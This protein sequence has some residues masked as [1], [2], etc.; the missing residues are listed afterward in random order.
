MSVFAIAVVLSLLYLSQTSDVATTGYDITALQDEKQTLEA[1]NEQLRL[2]IDQLESLD[3]VDREA[4]TRL[5]MGPPRRVIYVTAA[6]VAI[7]TPVARPTPS[8]AE[9]GGLVDRLSQ[10]VMGFLA[11]SLSATTSALAGGGGS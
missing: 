11:R 6:P 10:R 8:E 9:S 2:Q 4:T 1:E 7:P 5:Q 3:R